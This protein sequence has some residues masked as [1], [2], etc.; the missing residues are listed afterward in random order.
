MVRVVLTGFRGTGKTAVGERLAAL[1]QVPF[2]DT[3]RLVEE[4]AGRPIPAIFS[5]EGEAGFRLREH[6]VIAGLPAGDCVIS[7]GGGVVLDPG[8]VA[9]LRRDALVVHLTADPK[10]IEHRIRDTG[11]PA[12]TALPLREEIRELLAARRQ[13]YLSSADYTLDTTGRNVNEV[14]LLLLRRIRGEDTPAEA[15]DRFLSFHRG[16]PVPEVERVA[17]SKKARAAKT[18]P[19][20]SLYA[21]IGNPCSHS[22]SPPVFTRL[23]QDHL[24]DAAYTRIEWHDL[25]EIL[26]YVRAAGFRGLSVTLPFKETLIPLLDE[27]DEHTVA[28]G[29]ANTVLFT[30]GHA[31]GF[32]TDWTGIRDPLATWKGARAVVVGAGGAAAAA[33]YALRSLD[34]DVWVLNRTPGRATALAERHGCH[35]G[36][37]TVLKDLVPDVLVNATPVGM[38]PG[39]GIAIDPGTLGEGMVVFDLVYTPPE[40]P[41]IRAARKAGCSVIPGTEM[42]V[43]QACAQFRVFTG[44]DPDPAL[45]REVLA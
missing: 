23:F 33:V 32:N 2:S 42:F 10:T 21:V 4:Q 8:N 41:L 16:T 40:T 1:L 25:G 19:L 17:F 28:I 27:V 13:A 44:I 38:A 34:M 26:N 37:L 45:V 24:V 43:R 5:A 11:R 18:A 35:S 15:I 31:M 3:D 7:T 20:P 22:M 9:V 29:A 12:L 39:G 36:P 30:D 14:C 6:R